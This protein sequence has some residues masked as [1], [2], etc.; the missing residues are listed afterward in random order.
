MIKPDHWIK[1]FCE[2]G[3]IEPFNIEHINPASYDVMVGDHFICPTRDPEEVV[4]DSFTLFPNEVTLATTIEYVRM[5]RDVCGLLLLK[6]SLGRLWLNHSMSGWI[7][8]G[9]EGRLTLEFQNLGPV[10]RVLKKGTRVAQIVFFQL[11]EP[12]TKS[13]KERHDSHYIGQERAT[14][15]WSEMFFS[16]KL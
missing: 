5:P 12:P 10:P 11:S 4:C 7:D 8:P 15:A 3:G 1:E 14:R 9:F 13:Y 2:R 6:S 16:K